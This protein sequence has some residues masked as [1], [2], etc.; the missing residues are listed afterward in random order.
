MPKLVPTQLHWWKITNH[1]HRM[2]LAV[3][4]IL[5]LQNQENFVLIHLKLFVKIVKTG[6]C[7]I[8]ITPVICS[9]NQNRPTIYDES[10]VGS[11]YLSAFFTLL[12]V[13]VTWLGKECAGQ[14]VQMHQA[15]QP[16][17]PSQTSMPSHSHPLKRN[18]EG[19]QQILILHWLLSHIIFH[20]SE[21]KTTKLASVNKNIFWL[22]KK[23]SFNKNMHLHWSK[24]GAKMELH[25][26][27]FGKFN[28]M[29]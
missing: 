18:E 2:I 15:V 1:N 28:C 16:S 20:E 27:I 14:F 26:H 9:L 21:I 17:L 4:G 24:G 8:L 11:H 12:F 10:P 13:L 7:M 29:D 22:V 3:L 19:H 23:Y 5:V 6:Y 25:M